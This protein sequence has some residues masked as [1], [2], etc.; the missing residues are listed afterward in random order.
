M[1]PVI[2]VVPVPAKSKVGADATV[3][4]LFTPKFE[5]HKLPMLFVID[6]VVVL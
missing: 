3:L 2:V 4:A 6:L 1:T 5:M